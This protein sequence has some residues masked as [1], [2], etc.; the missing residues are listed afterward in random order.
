VKSWVIAACVIGLAGCASERSYIW[1][2][3]P[4]PTDLEFRVDQLTCRGEANAA[5]IPLVAGMGP[6]WTLYKDCMEKKGYVKQGR[7]E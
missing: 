1:L 3:D 5:Y 4:R 2:R 7:R 6:R